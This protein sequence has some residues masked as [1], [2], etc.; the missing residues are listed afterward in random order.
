MAMKL[1]NNQIDQGKN[2][3]DA[4]RLTFFQFTLLASFCLTHIKQLEKG[5]FVSLCMP[6]KGLV[7]YMIFCD[8]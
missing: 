2:N 8:I 6:K 7:A 4:A 1:E 5:S 3:L